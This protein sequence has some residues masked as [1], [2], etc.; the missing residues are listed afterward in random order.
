MIPGEIIARPGEIE[1]NAGR[2]TM[3]LTVVNI[4]DDRCSS[5]AITISTQDVPIES[6][7]PSWASWGEGPHLRHLLKKSSNTLPVNY[8]ALQIFKG[9]KPILLC[10]KFSIKIQRSLLTETYER[11]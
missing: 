4:G 3:E 1:L 11:G 7:S 5:A 2:P 8:K 6:L 9:L 10:V